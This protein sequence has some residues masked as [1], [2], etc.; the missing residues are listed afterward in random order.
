MENQIPQFVKQLFQNQ[1]GEEI[2]IKIIEGYSKRRV[3][4]LRANV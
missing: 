1:Y 2:T 4:T 3:V